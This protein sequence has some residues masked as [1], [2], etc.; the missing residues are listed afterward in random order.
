[1]AK[2]D[3]KSKKPFLDVVDKEAII[4]GIWAHSISQYHLPRNLYFE[5]ANKLKK[6][7]YKGFGRTMATVQFGTPNQ[8]LLTELRTNIYVFSAAKTFQQV[9]AMA[10]L[11]QTSEALAGS[12][13]FKEFKIE[14]A[15]IYDVF[16]EN[17][18]RSEYI[19]AETSARSAI[20]W[21]NIQENKALFPLIRYS[22]VMDSHTCE[23]CG[24]LDGTVLPADDPFWD[25]FMPPQ[26][27]CCKCLVQQMGEDDADVSTNTDELAETTR[28]KM[29]GLFLF[30]PGKDGVVFKEAGP[31]KHPYFDVAPKYSKLAQNNFNLPIPNND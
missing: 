31:D 28:S 7:L 22:A 3:D 11:R 12:A 30:N 10:K 17:Y 8:K 27:F 16:N 4:T 19:T 5:T 14:A 1:M 23:I 20:K 15:K 26:H 9:D 6:K 29:D 2:T 13:D 21:E 24:P 25:D 18:L